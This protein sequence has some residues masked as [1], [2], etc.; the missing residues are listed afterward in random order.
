MGKTA[1]E[2]HEIEEIRNQILENALDII[3]KDGYEALSMRRLGKRMNCTAKTIYNYFS[4]K[5]EIYLRVLTRGFE[6][7][8]EQVQQAAEGVEDPLERM[9]A[10]N[11]AYVHFGI[12]YSNYY[13][14]MFNLNTPKYTDYINTPMEPAARE[15]R[16]TAYRFATLT[17]EALVDVIGEGHSEDEILY[18]LTRMWAVTHGVV[19]L[20]NSRGMAEYNER[21]EQFLSRITESVIADLKNLKKEKMQ[22]DRTPD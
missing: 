11:R 14:I 16:D 21:S 10:M 9:Y 15:E 20:H 13:N 7:L 18:Q 2:F 22:Y 4:C 17:W 5:E 19:S 3:G 1:R 8:T 12:T 6:M